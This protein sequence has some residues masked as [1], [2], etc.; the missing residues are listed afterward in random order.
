MNE[1]LKA[2]SAGFD[3]RTSDP[4]LASPSVL[5]RLPQLCYHTWSLKDLQILNELHN[6]VAVTVSGVFEN[7]HRF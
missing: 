7:P 6:P 1:K 5:Y 2:L 4:P 3:Q